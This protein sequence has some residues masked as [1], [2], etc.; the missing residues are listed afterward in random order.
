MITFDE[1]ISPLSI[2]PNASNSSLRIYSGSTY[3]EGQF[4]V[5][6]NVV[7]FSPLNP[8][9]AGTQ[10]TVYLYNVQDLVGNRHCCTALRFT[11]AQ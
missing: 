2:E 5:N 11:T 10:V 7:T 1:A 3:F 6:N 8:F 4:S 9:P